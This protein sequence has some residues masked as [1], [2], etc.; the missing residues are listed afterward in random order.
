MSTVME[1]LAEGYPHLLESI[2][3]R[4]DDSTLKNS[5]L[6]SKKWRNFVDGFWLVKQI[7]TYKTK[8]LGNNISLIDLHE[9]WRKFFLY[10]ESDLEA[11]RLTVPLMKQYY[12]CSKSS[13]KQYTPLHY[14]VKKGNLAS[15]RY[16]ENEEL[17]LQTLDKHGRN[18]LHIA[19]L[20]ERNRQEIL[21]LLVDKIDVNQTDDLGNTP[22]HVLCHNGDSNLRDFVTYLVSFKSIDVNVANRDGYTP[23]HYACKA[24]HIDNVK[25]LLDSPSININATNDNGWT[26][27]HLACMIG[28]TD[29]VKLFL[30]HSSIDVQLKDSKGRTPLTLAKQNGHFNVVKQ[31]DKGT[32]CII[33]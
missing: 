25:S 18:L 6:V 15:V 20:S 17:N 16:F 14:A 30:L 22:L 2:L 12:H 28:F 31:F 9:D 3:S 10:L 26:P 21:Q 4:L 29:I 33:L 8:A 5:R 7:K 23:L 27:L 13:L 32:T 19:C 24:G 1:K 11:L